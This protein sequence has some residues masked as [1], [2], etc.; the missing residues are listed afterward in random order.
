[1]NKT[2][3]R[4]L[5]VMTIFTTTTLI[6]YGGYRLC[7]YAIEVITEKIKKNV[8]EGVRK[9]IKDTFNPFKWMGK[10]FGKKKTPKEDE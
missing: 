7:N 6:T 5:I 4:L 2:L 10:M 9:S 8:A 1:M 3:K